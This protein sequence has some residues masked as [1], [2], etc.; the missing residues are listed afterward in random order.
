VLN[1]FFGMHYIGQENSDQTARAFGFLFTSFTQD[2]ALCS[3]GPIRGSRGGP[4]GFRGHSNRGTADCRHYERILRKIDRPSVCN[5]SRL[6]RCWTTRTCPVHRT[7]PCMGLRGSTD[8]F[9][10]GLRAVR[11]PQK[12]RSRKDFQ[13]LSRSPSLE[14]RPSVPWVSGGLKLAEHQGIDDPEGQSDVTNCLMSRVVAG[15]RSWLSVSTSTP[16]G[17]GP[18][19]RTGPGSRS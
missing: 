14:F 2:Q 3:W 13:G 19:G 10:G 5:P 1:R 4:P 18:W 17:R 11:S 9:L 15:P 8:L 6:A 7:G 12:V 16:V